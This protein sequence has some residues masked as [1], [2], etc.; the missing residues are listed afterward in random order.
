[1]KVHS[2][3]PV[4]REEALVQ[5]VHLVV[6]L[7]QELQASVVPAGGSHGLDTHT[8]THRYRILQRS[9]PVGFPAERKHTVIPVIKNVFITA[10]HES[11][12]LDEVG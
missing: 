10:P 12:V 6:V 2:Q 3:G 5:V 11:F 7:H 8:Q 9:M 1:M 4:R